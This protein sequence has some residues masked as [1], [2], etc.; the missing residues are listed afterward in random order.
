MIPLETLSRLL[1]G[2][3]PCCTP[4]GTMHNLSHHRQGLLAIYKSSGIPALVKLLRCSSFVPLLSFVFLLSSSLSHYCLPCFP[5]IVFLVVLL[6]SLFFFLLS[7][8]V[9]CC[10][11]CSFIVLFAALV[12]FA[13]GYDFVVLCV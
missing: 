8:C 5:S 2:A 13:V 12:F 9:G 11:F 3:P 6:S 7:H 4:A 10:F 1:S